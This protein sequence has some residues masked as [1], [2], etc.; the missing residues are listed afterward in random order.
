MMWNLKACEC[1]CTNLKLIENMDGMLSIARTNC[2]EHIDYCSNLDEAVRLW[3]DGK[4]MEEDYL[5]IHV[6]ES[7]E[8]A[9][10]PWDD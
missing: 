8:M 9:N 2:S 1:G 4:F 6:T 7:R 3:N 5:L 10:L